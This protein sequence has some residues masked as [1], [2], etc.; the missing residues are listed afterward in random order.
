ME[1]REGEMNA[2]AS[3]M[4]LAELHLSLAKVFNEVSQRTDFKQEAA[5]I[6]SPPDLPSLHSVRTQADTTAALQSHPSLGS[7]LLKR[8]SLQRWNTSFDACVKQSD[9]KNTWK[10]PWLSV[11]VVMYHISGTSCISRKISGMYA[12]RRRELFSCWTLLVH[13]LNALA[14]LQLLNCW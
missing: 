13:I 5:R 7:K 14:F 4:W 6:L 12:R 2:G 3:D 9:L 10:A 11:H 8:L 1:A